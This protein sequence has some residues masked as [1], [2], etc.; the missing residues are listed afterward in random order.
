MRPVGKAIICYFSGTGNTELIAKG[1]AEALRRRGIDT[2]LCRMEDVLNGKRDAD[3][4]DYGLIGIGHP[5]YGFGAPRLAET[6]ALQLPA[7]NDMPVFVFKTASSP[8][9]VNY[10]ASNV[11]ICRLSN[12]GYRVFHNS[13]LAMPCNF[14]VKYDDRLNKQ[15]YRSALGKLE[16]LA[17]EIAAGSVRELR[18]HPLL[19]HVLRRLYVWEERVAGKTF[20]KGLRVGEDCTF[21]LKC[22]RNCPVGNIA[23]EAGSF[24]FGADCLLCMRCVY[25]CPRQAVKATRL[26]GS[27][28]KPFTGGL[29]LSKLLEDPDNDGCYVTGR[30]KGYYKH[31]IR[32]LLDTEQQC[33]IRKE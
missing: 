33:G 15:L 24:T 30:S 11:L 20:A 1:Y 27:V 26:R 19:E 12:N 4:S 18:V 7:G 17:D 6:F 29:R 23:L 3:F 14:Y 25:A 28:V 13:L 16:L 9:R 22:V 5:V 8:H 31:F 2:G 10:S 21:C 32:Y